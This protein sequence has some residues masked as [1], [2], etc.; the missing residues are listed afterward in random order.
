MD[1]D[2]STELNRIRTDINVVRARTEMELHAIRGDIAA[3][4]VA[5]HALIE[6]HPDRAALD[7]ALRRHADSAQRLA[8][9]IDPQSAQSFHE[10][11]R[12][13]L[14]TASSERR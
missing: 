14:A 6:T 11:V 1:F 2:V 4:S 9:H 10:A 12:R 13:L 8:A 5:V 3:I 7:R